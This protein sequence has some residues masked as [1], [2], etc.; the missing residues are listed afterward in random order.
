MNEFLNM[1][2]Y[3]IYVWPCYGLTAFCLIG[4]VVSARVS[5][6]RARLNALQRIKSL[7]LKN[8]PKA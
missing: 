4:L 3:A 2:G 8:A 6:R 5:L 1:G 7:E